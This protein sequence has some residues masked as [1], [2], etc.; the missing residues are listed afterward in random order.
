MGNAKGLKRG[1][2]HYIAKQIYSEINRN[3]IKLVK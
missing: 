3:K 2:V 1:N